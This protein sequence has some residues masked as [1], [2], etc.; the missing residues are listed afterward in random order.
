MSGARVDVGARTAAVGCV[1]SVPAGV[2]AGEAAA[3]YI[4]GMYM[5]VHVR[6]TPR[7]VDAPRSSAD[8]YLPAARPTAAA[9]A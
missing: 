8:T 9:V 3:S 5:C 2:T 7:S 1:R 6:T 4:R